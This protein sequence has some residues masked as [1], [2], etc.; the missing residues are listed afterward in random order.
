MQRPGAPWRGCARS[1][2][3]A[4]GSAR[5]GVL[6]AR[7]CPVGR[8]QREEVPGGGSSARGRARSGVA[9]RRD[10]EL[11]LDLLGDEDAAGLE[12]GVPG[13][14]PVL[15]VDAGAALE[16]DA[17]VAERVAG[18]AGRLEGDRDRL[19][20]PLD[21][22]LTGDD[23]VLAVALDLGRGEGDLLV[24]V[25]VEEVGRAEV[26]VAVGDTGVDAAG[27]DGQL[28]LRVGGVRGVDVRGAGEVGELAA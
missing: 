9:D 3:P 15:A 27:L 11:E 18:R 21:G 8:P 22:Q 5:W 2:V 1:S 14:A 20:L 24:V 10:V 25:G 26:A 7:N 17:Q 12:R 23:P 6:S 19:G 4:R 28:N 13:E 16:A